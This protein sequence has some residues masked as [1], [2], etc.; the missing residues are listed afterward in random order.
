MWRYQK[1]TSAEEEVNNNV[2]RITCSVDSQPHS[3]AIP[4]IAHKQRSIG[5]RDGVML[6]HMDFHSPRLT[7]LQLLLI[8]R[9]THSKRLTLSPR[10]GTKWTQLNGTE[11]SSQ[12][13]NP[14]QRTKS[15]QIKG[16]TRR[17]SPP[18][19]EHINQLFHAKLSALKIHIQITLFEL[20][21]LYLGI[22]THTHT[23]TPVLRIQL[24]A[25]TWKASTVPLSYSPSL[26]HMRL[27]CSGWPW[28]PAIAFAVCDNRAAKELQMWRCCLL[29]VGRWSQ[30]VGLRGWSSRL[31]HDHSPHMAS[32]ITRV[33]KGLSEE[34]S[35]GP[36]CLSSRNNK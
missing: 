26:F 31:R 32:S 24:W 12:G 4:M 21:G 15:N 35:E 34:P 3:P 9:S 8:A 17:G 5:G 27:N 25:L 6:D 1:V 23:H 10:C 2:D 13:L 36:Y 29:M 16:G 33:S 20:N 19:G 28:T 22:W 14:T 30:E 11:K 18:Q 7:W